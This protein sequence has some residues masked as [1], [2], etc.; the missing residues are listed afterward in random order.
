MTDTNQGNGKAPLQPP[1]REAIENMLD[2]ATSLA[3]DSGATERSRDYALAADAA[4]KVADA[5]D[6]LYARLAH[7]E[8]ETTRLDAMDYHRLSATIKTF[9]SDGVDYFSIA[10]EGG[11]Q[12]AFGLTIRMALD[13]A[14]LRLR[15]ASDS[16]RAPQ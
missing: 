12:I 15:G 7:L 4:R 14:V 11:K 2:E 8:A 5:L 13:D 16:E 3:Q 6:A 9:L 1:T 10:G